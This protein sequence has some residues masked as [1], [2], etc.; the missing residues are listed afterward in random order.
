MK[1]RAEIDGLRSLAVVPVVLHH[2][3][4]PWLSGGFVGVDVFFVIS[5]FLITTIILGDLEAGRFSLVTFYERR[6]RRILPALFLMLGMCIPPALFLMV[7]GELKDFGQ[8][9]VATSVFASNFLFWLQ[10]G[11]FAPEAELS[12]LLHTWSLAVEEQFYIL[13]PLLLMLLVGLRVRDPRALFAILIL[14]SLG[15]SH[16]GVLHFANMAFYLLPFRA[17]ELLIGALAAVHVMRN[18]AP[19]ASGWANLWA[20]IGLVAVILPNILYDAGTPFPG[21]A[22]APPVLGTAL[23]LVFGHKTT[24]VARLLSLKGFV[25]IGLISYSAYLLHQPAFVFFRLWVGEEVAHKEAMLPAFLA[26]SVLSFLG[27]WAVWRYIE[28]PFRTRRNG[29]LSRR[30]IFAVSLAGMVGFTAIGLTG[31]VTN[32]LRDRYAVPDFVEAGQFV[33]ATRQTG[34]CFYSFNEGTRLEIGAE[35]LTCALGHL[36]GTNGEILVFGDSFAAHWGPFW[37]AWGRDHGI[38]VAYVS[39]N[40]CFPSARRDSTAP[41]A[42]PS[43]R[44]CAV[45][46]AFLQREADRFNAVVLAGE[47]NEVEEM[48]FADGVLELLRGFAPELRLIV[49]DVPAFFRRRHVEARIYNPDRALLPFEARNAAGARMWARLTAALEERENT[50]LLSSETLFGTGTEA[51]LTPEGHPYSLDGDHI[52]IYGAEQSYARIKKRGVARDL[53]AFATGAL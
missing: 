11:Y 17:W 13:F 41:A 34:H 5:G 9:L 4:L 52:S 47:W 39:T 53:A 15:L 32:G 42:H 46:R 31:H 20:T 2:A 45:N 8:S 50:V 16:W 35:G 19:A 30:A 24:L 38:R 25:G 49:M 18:P 28:T 23:I 48:G 36:D 7:P 6:A 51:T 37:D 43:I 29:L 3:G 10:S 21:L 33:L 12:P 14:G 44:Q 22:A 27:A 26:L 1:Y 40:W